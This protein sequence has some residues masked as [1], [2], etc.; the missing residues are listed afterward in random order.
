M[1]N[2][3]SGSGQINFNTVLVIAVGALVSLGIEKA[4]K[5]FTQIV[6]LQAQH[7]ELVR[8]VNNIE[9]VI[10]IFVPPTKKP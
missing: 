5:A 7:D 8:R 9:A 4:D 3:K 10:G 1:P 2:E 6:V